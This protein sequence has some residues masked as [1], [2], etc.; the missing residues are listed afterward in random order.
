MKKAFT[1]IELVFVIV[2]LGVLSSIA[3]TKMAT[4][5]DDAQMVKGRSE[6]SAIRSSITLLRSKNMMS[7]MSN[8]GNPTHLDDEHNTADGQ[9]FDGNSS[10][11]KLLE[12][13]IYE[14][15]ANGRWRKTAENTYKF[16]VLN[17][18]IT[19][20]YNGAGVFDCNHSAG[21]AENTYCQALTE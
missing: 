3:I 8:G 7:G 15:D 11:G 2:V 10:T 12:Y 13:P 14:K 1:M 4:T 16:K 5:R 17:T 20:T 21:V 9:L 6:V 18:D 19:F